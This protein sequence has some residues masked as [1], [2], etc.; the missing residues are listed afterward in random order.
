MSLGYIDPSIR[1]IIPVTIN[2]RS[3]V[4]PIDGLKSRLNSNPTAVDD[5]VIL[6]SITDFDSPEVIIKGLQ[7]PGFNDQTWIT[8]SEAAYLKTAEYI[9]SKD[10]RA[11]EVILKYLV[12]FFGEFTAPTLDN[13]LLV[14]DFEEISNA[15]GVLSEGSLWTNLDLDWKG[16]STDP[17][18]RTAYNFQA[19]TNDPHSQIISAVHPV[20]DR[21]SGKKWYCGSDGTG[22]L[23]NANLSWLSGRESLKSIVVIGDLV[24]NSYLDD[25][26]LA[27]DLYYRLCLAVV[28]G[29]KLGGMAAIRISLPVNRG[30]YGIYALFSIFFQRSEIV[31]LKHWGPDD[32]TCY[33]VGINCLQM[34]TGFMDLALGANARNRVLSHLTAD[35]NSLGDSLTRALSP[36]IEKWIRKVA[37]DWSIRNVL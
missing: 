10:I 13:V 33:L 31:S 16:L 25:G 29:C 24:R 4:D 37:S 14:G 36:A 18:T 8:L 34:P 6:E 35:Y 5:K 21:Y 15:V 12:Q 26:L 19:F 9:S 11:H 30:L 17:Y 27:V 32:N 23:S 20:Y 2:K 28:A 3:G 7:L 1:A 22:L